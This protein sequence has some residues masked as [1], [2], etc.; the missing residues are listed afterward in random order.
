MKRRND[1]TCLLAVSTVGSTKAASAMATMHP[2]VTKLI[3]AGE[4]CILQ[5]LIQRFPWF[6]QKP[7]LE[8]NFHFYTEKWYLAE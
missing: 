1:L 7:P 6:Q 8:S 4:T 2:H 3:T 5:W